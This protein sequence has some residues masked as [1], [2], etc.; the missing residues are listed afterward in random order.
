MLWNP[1]YNTL[2]CMYVYNSYAPCSPVA[3]SV[4]QVVAQVGAV[5]RHGLPV[6]QAP[7]VLPHHFFVSETGPAVGL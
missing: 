2:M 4:W 7:H 1:S 3:L 5:H 6:G